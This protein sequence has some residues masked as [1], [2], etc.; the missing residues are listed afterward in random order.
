MAVLAP[1]G[2]IECWGCQAPHEW[3]QRHDTRG[4]P[5]VP[6]DPARLLSELQAAARASEEFV[7]NLSL[8]ASAAKCWSFASSAGMRK[9]LK[10]FRLFG[11]SMGK[12]N[13]PERSHLGGAH[14]H[15]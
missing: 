3:R 2:A 12:A 9:K 6:A 15:R 14:P 10:G 5:V 8:T 11:G 4:A 13:Q 1:S 7:Q